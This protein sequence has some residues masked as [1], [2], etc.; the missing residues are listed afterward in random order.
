VNRWPRT[1]AD[2]LISL[3]AGVVGTPAAAC[4]RPGAGSPPRVASAS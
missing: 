2:L 3:S 4:H 1:P